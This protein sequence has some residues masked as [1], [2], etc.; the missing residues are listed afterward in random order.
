M[1][2]NVH[3]GRTESSRVPEAQAVQSPGA[4][5]ADERLA[6]PAG[7]AQSRVD[8]AVR[9]FDRQRLHDVAGFDVEP[10]E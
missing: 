9:V 5:L 3:A 1:L 10:C 6:T 2:E 7:A 4:G 8:I